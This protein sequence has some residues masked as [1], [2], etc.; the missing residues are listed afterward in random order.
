MHRIIQTNPSFSTLFKSFKLEGDQMSDN[1]TPSQRTKNMQAIK[2]VS[3]LENHVAGELW[4]RGI[5]FRRNVKTLFGKPDIAIKKYKIVIFID[6]CFWH[7]CP[8]HGNM[9][10][11]N[12]DY[13]KKK[14]D[15]NKARDKD[16]NEFYK[17]NHWNILRVW[18]HA[19]KED[20]DDAVN[21]IE[22][23]IKCIKSNSRKKK[24]PI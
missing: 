18:E 20:F 7:C 23:F 3:K 2:S 12:F 14:L 15:R 19:F 5:R 6:S 8:I 24:E 17:E 21:K 1:L 13:W 4:K 9:P 22:D 16:V 10:K 11:S